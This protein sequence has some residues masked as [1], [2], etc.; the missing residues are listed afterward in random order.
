VLSVVWFIFVAIMIAAVVID[1][2]HYRI[3]NGLV[4]A[5][6]ALF[7]IVATVNW[8]EVL[9]VSHFAAAILIFGAGIFLYALKQMGAGDVK[10]LAVV[11]LWA[12]VEALVLSYSTFPCVV[13]DAC[14]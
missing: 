11:A 5:L 7:A 3:P 13:L 8:N 9:W 10:L 6:L 12:G 2:V 14:W 4:I 1:L